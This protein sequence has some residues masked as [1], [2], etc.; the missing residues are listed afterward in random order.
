MQRAESLRDDRQRLLDLYLFGFVNVE[1]GE[2]D[3]LRER[4]IVVLLEHGVCS[5]RV[6][7]KLPSHNHQVL[8]KDDTRLQQQ[9]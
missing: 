1:Q 6:I 4:P 3:V 2:L 5:N 9:T 7:G 8:K